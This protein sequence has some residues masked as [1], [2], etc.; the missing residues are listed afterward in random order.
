M[1][2]LLGC[3]GEGSSH[4]TWDAIITVVIHQV[5]QQ[6]VDGGPCLLILGLGHGHQ[7]VSDV[8][9]KGCSGCDGLLLGFGEVL[10]DCAGLINS[11]L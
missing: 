4:G 8:V 1:A 7:A 11:I 2:W 9:G 3:W 5:T 10:E 6:P